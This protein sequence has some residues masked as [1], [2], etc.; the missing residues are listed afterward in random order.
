MAW[1]IPWLLLLVLLPWLFVQ[2][3]KWIVAPL[4]VRMRGTMSLLP[5]H[6]PA[7]SE[8]LTPELRDY[9][10]AII[11]QFEVVGFERVA[12]LYHDKE[13]PDVTAIEALLVNRTTRDTGRI[14]ACHAK[15]KRTLV[16]VISSGFADG[17]SIVT[18]HNR[19]IGIF[20]ANPAIDVLTVSWVTDVA[21]LCEF[22]RR[23]IERAGRTGQPRSI[24]ESGQEI[25]YVDDVANRERVRLVQAGYMYA[26]PARGV[27]RYTWKGAILCVWKLTEPVKGWRMRLRDRAARRIWNELAMDRWQSSRHTPPPL[28]LP[29]IPASA[30]A[31]VELAYQ[32]ALAE[33]ELR[34]ERTTEGLTIRMGMPTVGA[35][36]RRRWFSFVTIGFWSSLLLFYGYLWG[37]STLWSLAGS[38]L[39]LLRP[40][41]ILWFVA[42]ATF[43]V[44]DIYRLWA[45]VRKL[46]GEISLSASHAGLSFRN[47]P[48]RQP[49]GFVPRE[50]LDSLLV[51]LAKLGF[52]GREYRLEARIRGNKRQ[53]LLNGTNKEEMDKARD[54]IAQAMGIDPALPEPT[55]TAAR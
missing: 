49:T 25:A 29:A 26:D 24:P 20:P 5:A 18:A 19:D 22:H 35:Y 32:A 45:G 17:T 27:Y 40:T 2:V 43:L 8:H 15:L 46:R 6:R 4:L 50:R 11:S 28:P 33:G 10:A 3:V 14:V 23:R 12:Q 37:A 53:V 34:Q 39:P 41:F 55:P 44:F 51:V 31:P 54:A 16:Y 9:I 36:L 13:M 7:Q 21:T 38:S 1:W 48:A 30:S 47:A 42:C 52:R